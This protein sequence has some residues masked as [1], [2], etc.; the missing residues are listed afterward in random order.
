MGNMNLFCKEYGDTLCIG[1]FDDA[2]KPIDEYLAINGFKIHENILLRPDV[3]LGVDITEYISKNVKAK[4]IV[5]DAYF[6]EFFNDEEKIQNIIN[7][8]EV[9]ENNGFDV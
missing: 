5:I 3:D 8:L 6:F 2:F 4:N 1:E 9:L 7:A